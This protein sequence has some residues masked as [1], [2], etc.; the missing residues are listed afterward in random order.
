MADQQADIFILSS[1]RL[2][3]GQEESNWVAIFRQGNRSAKDG[4]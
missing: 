3:S 2:V 1:A 4:N